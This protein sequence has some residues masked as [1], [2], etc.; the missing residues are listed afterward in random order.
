STADDVLLTRAFTGLP[1]N[2]LRP[3]ILA[4]GLDPDALPEHGGID[5]ATDL[6]ADRPWRWRDIWSAGHSVSAV[7]NILPVA[8]LIHAIT[9]EYQATIR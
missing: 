3:S 2:M 1:T 9:A 4:A 7:S 6:A 8:T 5:V